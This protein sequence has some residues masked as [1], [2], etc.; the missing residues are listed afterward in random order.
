MAAPVGST[1]TVL[2]RISFSVRDDGLVGPG[3]GPVGTSFAQ[4]D[5][6]GLSLWR[7]RLVKVVD[8]A[9][10]PE[11]AAPSYWYR[12]F[13]DGRAALLRRSPE[14]SPRDR[15]GT[16]AQ[17]LVGEHLGLPGALLSALGA[18]PYLRT[19]LETPGRTPRGWATV[20]PVTLAGA[21][22]KVRRLDEEA[23]AHPGLP[24]LVARVLEFPLEPLD[25]LVPDRGPSLDEWERLLL[26]WGLYRALRDIVGEERS[27]LYEGMEW[28]FSTYEPWPAR[29]S[30]HQERPRIAF[31]P[32]SGP[33]GPPLVDVLAPERADEYHL[34][35]RWLVGL[36]HRGPAELS[37]LGRETRAAGDHDSVLDYLYSRAREQALPQPPP[38]PPGPPPEP[39][40]APRAAA[41]PAAPP[42]PAPPGPEPG[43]GGAVEDTGERD[44]SQPPVAPS[45]PVPAT[46][47]R[48]SE[49]DPPPPQAWA[50][51]WQIPPPPGARPAA[52]AAP[53]SA[54]AAEGEPAPAEVQRL[55]DDLAKA[56]DA[57][58]M[59]AVATLI[60]RLHH[61]GF[62]QYLQPRGY[63][64]RRVEIR[65][66]VLLVLVAGLF[67]LVAILLAANL[68]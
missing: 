57:H 2:H 67:L 11:L 10:P 31:R 24:A 53:R 23:A 16:R 35:A 5:Y 7:D 60:V 13:G 51:P 55:L 52:G 4:E 22:W 43:S 9:L 58:E 19:W 50:D 33:D 6:N 25:V 36:L 3:L 64:G 8:P 65:A 20:D 56:H 30:A 28:S 12:R 21:E 40:P 63:P 18:W 42:P 34:T 49:P 37:E 48:H 1:G 66:E 41:G 62:A 26:L 46:V 59:A 29:R 39:D 47:G 44:R 54:P 68:L 14:D 38:V 32:P 45:P 27:P 15:R 61:P 17:A